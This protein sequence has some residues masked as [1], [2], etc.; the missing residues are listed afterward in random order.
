[1]TGLVASASVSKAEHRGLIYLRRLTG[2]RGHPVLMVS[3]ARSLGVVRLLADRI[4]ACSACSQVRQLLFSEGFTLSVSSLINTDHYTSHLRKRTCCEC[5]AHLSVMT[6]TVQMEAKHIHI[7]MRNICSA[8]VWVV[9]V[10][11]RFR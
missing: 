9:D 11:V 2:V 4:S 3:S 10:T 5:L 1:M 7:S 6:Q 8:V